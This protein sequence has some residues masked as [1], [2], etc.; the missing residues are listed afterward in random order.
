MLSF[1]SVMPVGPEP[2]ILVISRAPRVSYNWGC[3]IKITIGEIEFKAPNKLSQQELDKIINNLLLKKEKILL[4]NKKNLLG[5][6]QNPL[7]FYIVIN[8][9]TKLWEATIKKH[10]ISRLT[11]DTMYNIYDTAFQPFID[12]CLNMSNVNN[13]IIPLEECAIC[14]DYY[15][16]YKYKTLKCKHSFCRECIDKWHNT[17]ISIKQGL[18]CP[19]CKTK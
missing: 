4:K 18:L 15:N 6:I 12:T 19:L 11:K 9:I 13:Y 8:K 7:W 10:A 3:I 16:L 2:T 17:E 1:S 5:P 14:L